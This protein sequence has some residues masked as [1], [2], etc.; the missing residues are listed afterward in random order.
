[1]ENKNDIKAL[2]DHIADDVVVYYKAKRKKYACMSYSELLGALRM[3]TL[4]Q[5]KDQNFSVGIAF[6][7][8]RDACDR[9]DVSLRDVYE[10]I[11]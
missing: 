11:E 8:V 3:Y 4:L 9:H 5:V 6:D 7:A 1:M 2:F 10:Y